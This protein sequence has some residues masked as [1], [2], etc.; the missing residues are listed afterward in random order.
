ME[1][2][3]QQILRTPAHRDFSYLT[4]TKP[5]YDDLKL[6]ESQPRYQR[7]QI[8]FKHGENPDDAFSRIPYEKGAIFL[9]H[10]G[11]PTR[12]NAF[13]IWFGIITLY[14]ALV[15]NGPLAGWTSSSHI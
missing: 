8:D 13:H 7:L 15:Q 12:R 10:I 9:L 2:L 1:R 11:E 14:F 3:L 4:R 6:L 5:L